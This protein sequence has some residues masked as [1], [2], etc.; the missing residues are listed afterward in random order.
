MAASRCD[1]ERDPRALIR[2]ALARVAVRA[3][4]LP[5]LPPPGQDERFDNLADRFLAGDVST[6]D[7]PGLSRVDFLRW[8][9]EH[10]DV[11]FHG[12]SRGDL[13]V[14]EP[15]RLSTDARE[16]GN[17]QA[18]FATDDPV[19]AIWFAI[20][21]RGDGYNSTRNGSLRVAGDDAA[22]RWYFFTV[23]RGA[24][25]DERFGGGYLYVLPRATFE[26]EP[27]I[28]GV[29]DSAQWAS[30]DAV[31]PLVRVDVRPDDFP[32]L[33]AVHEHGDESGLVTILRAGRFRRR[34]GRTSR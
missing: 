26:R 6:L 33:D 32:L 3:A 8:L 2:A 10:R 7:E 12:S 25:S 16:F 18:V 9:G 17:R 5:R 22:S 13:A 29:L 27:P 19:W 1:R 20:L 21:H 34:A 11:L 4:G 28:A 15:I 24:L 14:L 31:R 23:N 30:F